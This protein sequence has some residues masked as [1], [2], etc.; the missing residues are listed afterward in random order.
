MQ[1]IR[2]GEDFNYVACFLTFACQLRCPYCINHHGGDLVIKRRMEGKDW[3]RGINRLVLPKDTPV[4]LQGGEPTVHKDFV[5]I[6]NGIREDIPIDILTNFERPLDQWL[7]NIDPARLR[8][9]SPYAS[10][11]ISWHKG[12]HDLREL[13]ERALEAQKRGYS[14]GIWSVCH[15]DYA[16]EV[17]EAQD[18]AHSMG[19][20]FRL[21]EF[22]GPHGGKVYGTFRYPNAVDDEY[23]RSCMCRTSELLISPNGDI[24]R[25]HSDL[26][27]GRVVVGSILEEKR[28]EA[29][30]WLGCSVY[31]KCNSCDIK[32]KNNRYQQWGH[33]SV[34]IKDISEPYA[35]N[36]VI[37][38][39]VNMYGKTGNG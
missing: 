10:I 34:E 36:E 14:V 20:D 37:K 19:I 18:L 30:R 24:H 27:A 29:G 6:V 7:Y 21:K 16:D 5:E 11:R 38:E 15:P 39:P 3:I 25:C 1:E 17:V 22:L 33:S 32:V 2:L 13:L 23:L 35:H 4:T 8:R 28:I 9:N 26:Y 12:Q 31:G